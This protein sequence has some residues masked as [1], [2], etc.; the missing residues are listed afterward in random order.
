MSENV[1]TTPA[2]TS[3][4]A[5]TGLVQHSEH[6]D[7]APRVVEVRK[8]QWG[9]RGSG[10]TT[11]FGGL[12]RE[13]VL[14]GESARPYGGWFDSVVDILEELI[15]EDGNAVSEVI[16]RVVVDRDELTIFIAR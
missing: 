15:C 8:G 6:G 16:Q 2:E 5:V 11:G 9:V 12:T 1:P 14:P 7:T 10:D 4:Q 13:V 3:G